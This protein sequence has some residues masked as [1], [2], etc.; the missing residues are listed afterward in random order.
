[1]RNVEKLTNNA[2][3]NILRISYPEKNVEGYE[4]AE[5]K[6]VDSI[7]FICYNRR[8]NMF[9]V[10]REYKPPI[11]QFICGA[12]G[13]SLDKDDDFQKIVRDECM[14]EAGYSVGKGQVE[15]V[16]KSFVSTQMNQYCYLFMVFVYDED[17]VGRH[18]ENKVE[19]M[20]TTA[21]VTE[22]EIIEGDDW[23][24]IAILLK[25]KANSLL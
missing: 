12:F 19:E 9:L 4:Y 20:A 14:E 13:G 22:R 6:G 17:F 7:A 21:W 10:N 3:L 25:A 11:D 15:F 23:K 2:F 16:G 24:A 8:T 5:R 18:P 1:M